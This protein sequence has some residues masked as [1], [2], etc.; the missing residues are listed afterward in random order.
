M[1]S[2]QFSLPVDQAIVISSNAKKDLSYI[3]HAEGQR[4]TW[5]MPITAGSLEMQ[6]KAFPGRNP[7]RTLLS[8]G[9]FRG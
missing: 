9:H 1:F 8:F 7:E 2:K 5:S 6:K 3:I 4:L